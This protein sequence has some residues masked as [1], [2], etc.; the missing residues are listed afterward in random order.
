MLDQFTWRIDL[1][2]VLLGLFCAFAFV[3]PFELIFEMLLD[4]DTKLKPFRIICL[5]II[6]V[7]GLRLLRGKFSLSTVMR[8]DIFIYSVF[9]YGLIISLL[10]IIT[11]IFH[12]GLF[13]NDIFQTGLLLA[14]FF[15][16]KN[17]VV[18]QTQSFRIMKFFI[19]GFL[20]N[21]LYTAYDYFVLGHLG[22]QSG[23]LDNPNYAGLGLTAIIIYLILRFNYLSGF[24]KKMG[25]LALMALFFTTFIIAGSRT[26]IV[27]ILFAGIVIFVFSKTQVKL[28]IT[29]FIVMLILALLP[30]R[31]GL[32]SGFAAENLANR[33]NHSLQSEEV[34][35]RLIVWEGIFRSLEENGFMGMGV[36]QFKAQFSQYYGDE[37][38]K[39]ILEIVNR[40]YHLSTHNDYLAVLTD[41]GI[42]GLILFVLF[43]LLS[44]KDK[45]LDLFNQQTDLSTKFLNQYS[46]IIISCLIIFGITAEN[47]PNPLYWFLLMMSTK[48]Y[49]L[50]KNQTIPAL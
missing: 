3:L 43:L 37:S 39:L 45:F 10:R 30:Q 27:M 49:Y 5:L 4:I 1:H 32:F 40:G 36:G 50:E 20:I 17:T 44:L 35:V 33:V 29:S 18:S 46:F 38:N 7:Y 8:T 47:F 41:Y 9:V 42:P 19:T 23:F 13:Y 14:T 28:F 22:R 15:I 11:G 31:L 21:S 48:M 2:K 26:S 34:D 6:G 16:F 24:K 25:Q 12:F